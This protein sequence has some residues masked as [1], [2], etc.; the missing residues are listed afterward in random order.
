[1]D[2]IEVFGCVGVRL[3]VVS[4]PDHTIVRVVIGLYSGYMVVIGVI[5]RGWDIGRMS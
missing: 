2:C 5:L 3:E 4:W 1:M